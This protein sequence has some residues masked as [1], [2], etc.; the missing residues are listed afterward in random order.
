MND[1]KDLFDNE[2]VKEFMSKERNKDKRHELKK[3]VNDI[4]EN[5]GLEINCID[6]DYNLEVSEVELANRI[7][8]EINELC[9]YIKV[10][11]ELTDNN[12][13]ELHII[14]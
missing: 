12:K 4:L 5:L 8:H 3:R 9:P 13:I 6:W 1:R 7:E 11:S 2:S 10:K 14:V